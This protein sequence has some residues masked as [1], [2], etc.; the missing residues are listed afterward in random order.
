MLLRHS[1]YDQCE[2]TLA[3]TLATWH[4]P[5]RQACKRDGAR[6]EAQCLSTPD[7][8][9][10]LGNYHGLCTMAS[11]WIDTSGNYPPPPSRHGADALQ[12][13]HTVL[14]DAI[15]KP[16]TSTYGLTTKY[17]RLVV[18]RIKKPIPEKLNALIANTFENEHRWTTVV[19]IRGVH[20]ALAPV[21]RM[22]M[23]QSEKGIWVSTTSNTTTTYT[24]SGET[25]KRR[26]PN[27]GQWRWI[28]KLA[29]MEAK[30]SPPDDGDCTTVILLHH[31]ELEAATAAQLQELQR[32][33][34]PLPRGTNQ[35]LQSRQTGTHVDYDPATAKEY[36][37]FTAGG[38][39]NGSSVLVFGAAAPAPGGWFRGFGGRRI[40]VF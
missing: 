26:L 35:S 13:L 27:N 40:R 21:L 6:A 14:R 19:A 7:G 28:P 17:H 36:T 10:D 25:T 4:F 15:T 32:C 39:P 33:Q 37:G 24:L 3:Q 18:R 30:C 20:D 16:G 5:C 29:T 22:L 2:A 31:S 1:D 23:K 11:L 8:P 34:F 9:V 12:V 38:T